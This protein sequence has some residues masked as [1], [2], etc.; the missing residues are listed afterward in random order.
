MHLDTSIAIASDHNGIDLKDFIYNCLRQ[1]KI[2]AIDLGPYTK[3]S[4]DYVDYAYQMGNIIDRGDIERGILICG[5]GVGMSIAANRF[6]NVR[7]SLIHNLDSAP[8]CR[9]HNDSNIL[10]L[11][12]WIT[13]PKASKLI[14]NEWLGTQFGEG[15][16]VKRVEKISGHKPQSIVFTNGV[17]DIL[18]AG[19]LETLKFAKS[20]G[21]KLVVG[22][23]SDEST[24]KIKG[25]QRPI[26]NQH[27]R[28]KILSYISL[29]DEVVIFDE[30]N[31]T[32][33]ISNIN[34]D[35]VVKGGEFTAAEIRKRDNIPNH[36][37]VKVA[38]LLDQD[39]YST[40]RVVEKIKQYA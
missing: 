15:R 37:D 18:H 13:T 1:K 35:I 11:G 28:K 25:P 34:P 19:H 9:E 8:K 38:S 29:V 5:T 24:K 14:L 16:H 30:P 27:D 2:N 23:N 20:L 39:I 7:A 17:F 33:I 40:T 6:K 21:D 3:E 4:V 10:C 36:I 32:N 22:I 26:N 12:S 31:T